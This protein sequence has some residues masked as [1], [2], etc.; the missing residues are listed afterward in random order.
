MC[1]WNVENLQLNSK[2]E[3]DA[4]ATTY[5]YINISVEFAPE[6][7][8]FIPTKKQ[9]SWLKVWFEEIRLC[10]IQYN[11]WGLWIVIVWAGFIGGATALGINK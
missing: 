9:T 3:N 10:V 6:K 7:L 1:L 2:F 8:D 11:M 5:F 4:M